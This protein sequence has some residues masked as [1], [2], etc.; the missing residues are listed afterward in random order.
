MAYGFDGVFREVEVSL[1]VGCH[2]LDVDVGYFGVV[3]FACFITS[4]GL[5]PVEAAFSLIGK[6]NS[7]VENF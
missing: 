1:F 2:L 5:E 3:V 4:V 7:F 6:S